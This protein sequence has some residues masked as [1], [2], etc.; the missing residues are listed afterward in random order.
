MHGRIEGVPHRNRNRN[1][2][3][4]LLAPEIVDV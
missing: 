1:P 4:D 2:N 3:S